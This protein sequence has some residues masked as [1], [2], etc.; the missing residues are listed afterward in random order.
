VRATRKDVRLRRR[1]SGLPLSRRPPLG[2][3][4]ATGPS[5]P[6]AARTWFPSSTGHVRPRTQAPSRSERPSSQAPGREMQR[7]RPPSR[8][9]LPRSMP[10]RRPASGASTLPLGPFGKRARRVHLHRLLMIGQLARL[11]GNGA[12]PAP[13]SRV[14]VSSV[15]SS[16]VRSVRNHV[17]CSTGR[18]RAKP[19][20]DLGGVSQNA[21][22][23]TLGFFALSTSRAAADGTYR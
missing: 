16:V 20:T 1:A 18:R 12:R 8:R 21:G 3:H 7:E 15:V 11:H 23:T 6:G 10:R 13:R 14:A 17:R 2:A 5:Q 19:A 9:P 4:P 22:S